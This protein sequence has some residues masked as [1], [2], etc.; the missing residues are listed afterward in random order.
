[1][2]TVKLLLLAV[3]LVFFGCGGSGGNGGDSGPAQVESL[4]SLDLNGTWESLVETKYF[5]ESTNDYLYSEFKVS[6]MILEDGP[7]GIRYRNCENEFGF[8]SFGVK[9]GERL[10][11]DTNEEGYDYLGGNRF[12][13]VGP[14]GLYSWESPDYV[15]TVHQDIITLR[16]I[17]DEV[18]DNAGSLVL[19]LPF[20]SD[21][22]ARSCIRE[23]YSSIGILGSFSIATQYNGYHIDLYVTG[24]NDWPVGVYEWGYDSADNTVIQR[25]W[26]DVD[27]ELLESVTGYGYSNPI[28]GV[29]EI[30]ENSDEFLSGSFELVDE[31]D[32]VFKGHFQWDK[33]W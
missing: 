16:K 23:Y 12:Q 19:D 7:S 11:L 5:N 26:V 1:M 33:N 22:N 14:L 29:V 20:S 13:Q 27:Y 2:K 15:T 9:S 10:Y 4:E 21:A 28:S 25:V 32:I 17:N 18:R 31:N 24:L 30:T 8:Y 6:R 3:V